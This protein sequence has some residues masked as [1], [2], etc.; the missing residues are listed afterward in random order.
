[1]FEKQVPPIP[2]ELV[3]KS[4]LSLDL[5]TSAF[6]ENEC[7]M[8]SFDQYKLLYFLLNPDVVVDRDDDRYFIQVYDLM[9]Q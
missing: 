9:D 3:D 5:L 1:M 8:C 2:S 4:N 7:T 6:L